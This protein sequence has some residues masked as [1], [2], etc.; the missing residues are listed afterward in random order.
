MHDDDDITL[1]STV[2]DWFNWTSEKSRNGILAVHEK[3]STPWWMTI[4]GVTVGLRLA[5]FPLR[6]RAWRNGR[7]IKLVTEYC[8]NNIAPNLRSNHQ[9][10]TMAEKR[11]ELFKK[12]MLKTH[13]TVMKHVGASPWKSLSPLPVSIPLFLSVAAA[14]RGIDYNGEGLGQVWKNF[15]EADWLSAV[16]VALSNFVYIEQARRSQPHVNIEPKSFMRRKLPFIVG[17]SL[18]VCSFLVLTTVPSS[19]NLFLLTSSLL[20]IAESKY[21]HGSESKEANDDGNKRLLDKW[22]EWGFKRKI[23]KLKLSLE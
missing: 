9:M 20:S 7:M 21:L 15:G 13:A 16:P 11:A 23:D 1:L 4:T 10:N 14:L 12:D 18:N 8:N 22:V 2:S 6:L 19:V 17:H 5:V 3:S